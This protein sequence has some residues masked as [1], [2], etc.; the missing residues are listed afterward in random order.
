MNFAILAPCY[1][2]RSAGI[3][4][5]YY[6][7][8]LLT[9][10]GH[11]VR[12]NAVAEND[13]IAIYPD[14]IEGNPMGLKRVIRYWMLPPSY[15]KRDCASMHYDLNI[16]Y[17]SNFMK[18]LFLNFEHVTHPVTI[19]SIEPGLFYPEM[20]SINAVVYSG[21]E[22]TRM[23]PRT[24]S[25]AILITRSYV[26]RD[27]FAAILRK[28]KCFYSMDHCTVA[29][30]EALLCECKV[31]LV[32]DQ[33]VRYSGDGNNYVQSWNDVELAKRFAGYAQEHFKV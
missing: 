12:M 16:P 2:A 20:K 14:C 18:E 23:L 29:C 21:K 25:K 15:W 28:T 10:C 6:L 26:K 4:V 13:D 31:F 5:I 30:E 32:K 27:E 8:Q 1:D 9:N 19:P 24:A 22:T 3:R 17:H 33:C 7:A 11:R